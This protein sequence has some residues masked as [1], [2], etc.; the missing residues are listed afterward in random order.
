MGGLMKGTTWN[1]AFITRMG[2]SI[3]LTILLTYILAIHTTF[4][5]ITFGFIVTAIFGAVYGPLR[6][7]IMAAI[8]C[9]IGMTLFGKGVFFPGFIL[10]EFL[11]GYIFGYFLH[12]KD[13]T[14]RRIL[15]PEALVTICLHL[16]LNTM[17]LVIFYGKAAD[18]IFMSRLIKNVLC[19]PLEVALIYMVY[20]AVGRYIKK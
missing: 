13:M 8:S 2:I 3:A 16:G 1:S 20:R 12:G 7:G 5:H 6:A 18:A 14:I 17:W 19:Y 15:L 4:V 9:L 10:T 11:R